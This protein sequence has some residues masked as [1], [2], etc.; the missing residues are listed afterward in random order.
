MLCVGH[1][2][3]H[4]MTQ[5]AGCSAGAGGRPGAE[6][7]DARGAYRQGVTEDEADPRAARKP[8]NDLDRAQA[9]TGN[10]LN[11]IGQLLSRSFF[12]S[13]RRRHTRSKRDWSSDVCSS[14]LCATASWPAWL[15]SAARPSWLKMAI[16]STTA[17]YT[18][19]TS[20]TATS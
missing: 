12:F 1:V 8:R 6:A 17:S 9:S 19:A 14:D 5:C 13:S 20:T 15:T 7:D 11:A 16:T 4:G 10:H 2:H 3:G 18:C